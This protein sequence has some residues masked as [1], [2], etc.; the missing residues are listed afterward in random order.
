MLICVGNVQWLLNVFG[1]VEFSMIR[2]RVHLKCMEKWFQFGF[3]PGTSHDGP[4]VG[5]MAS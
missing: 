4:Q 2:A 3:H 5:N 1:S